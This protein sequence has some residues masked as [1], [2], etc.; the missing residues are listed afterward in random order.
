MS[1]TKYLLALNQGKVTIQAS[2]VQPNGTP[3][4]AEYDVNIKSDTLRLGCCAAVEGTY[5]FRGDQQTIVGP[6]TIRDGFG[7]FLDVPDGQT[8]RF[9]TITTCGDNCEE[10]IEI[11][12]ASVTYSDTQRGDET[13]ISS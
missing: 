1:V 13:V 6:N 5:P 7:G 11:D 4:T 12:P 10:R 8:V 2:Y 3:I 9:V